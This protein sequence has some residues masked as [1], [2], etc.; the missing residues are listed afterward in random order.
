MDLGKLRY[1]YSQKD[2]H[3][4]LKNAHEKRF[5]QEIFLWLL[6][7][8]VLLKVEKSLEKTVSSTT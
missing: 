4:N 1:M 3:M 6:S 8:F 5:I 7:I 2:M